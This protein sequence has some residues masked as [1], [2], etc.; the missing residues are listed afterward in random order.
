MSS[1]TVPNPST[2]TGRSR[3]LR[4]AGTLSNAVSTTRPASTRQVT[5][6]RPQGSSR[7]KAVSGSRAGTRPVSTRKRP[8]AIVAWPHM[9]E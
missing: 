5:A 3:W 7:V 9:V 6:T 1:G 4:K 8:S 2:A